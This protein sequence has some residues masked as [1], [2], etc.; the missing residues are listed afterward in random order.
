MSCQ[1]T[2]AQISVMDAAD[3]GSIRH[4]SECEDCR[5]LADL[6]AEADRQIAEHV[7]AFA[8][9]VSFE[10]ALERISEN[11]TPTRMNMFWPGRVLVEP[12]LRSAA[13]HVE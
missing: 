4:L 11:P 10:V 8:T 9:R 7:D 3:F 13:F 2:R 12:L 1:D 5:A 6:A